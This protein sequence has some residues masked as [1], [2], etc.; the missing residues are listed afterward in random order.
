MTLTAPSITGRGGWADPGEINLCKA[1]G[2]T[3]PAQG[4]W[5]ERS[6]DAAGPGVVLLPGVKGPTRPQAIADGKP[7]PGEQVKGRAKSLDS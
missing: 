7:G 4:T 5:N 2:A 1:D 6:L 3:E